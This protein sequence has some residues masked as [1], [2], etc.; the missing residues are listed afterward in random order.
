MF[1][2]GQ[3]G[4]ESYQFKILLGVPS[5]ARSNPGTEGRWAS[6]TGAL[7]PRTFRS[8]ETAATSPRG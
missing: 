3:K 5:M 8:S 7:G 1:T 4:Q 6:Q 2:G